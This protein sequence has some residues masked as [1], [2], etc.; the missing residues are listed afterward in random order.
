MAAL[1]PSIA[2]K[3]KE[4]MLEARRTLTAP[5]GALT[6]KVQVIEN[7]LNG[8]KT[9]F[10]CGEEP[11]VADFRLYLWLSLVRSGCVVSCTSPSLVAFCDKLK[12][13]K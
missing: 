3:D 9:P 12:G 6:K 10:Y 4:E 1:A 13:K 11:T 2:M 5:D 7:V 8:C